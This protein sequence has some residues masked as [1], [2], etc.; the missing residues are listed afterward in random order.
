[1]ALNLPLTRTLLNMRFPSGTGIVSNS[2]FHFLRRLY[3]RCH[4]FKLFGLE[5]FF[6]FFFTVIGD[7][8]HKGRERRSESQQ[9]GESLEAPRR[10]RSIIQKDSLSVHFTL[11]DTSMIP[12]PYGAWFTLMIQI[13]KDPQNPNNWRLFMFLPF[14]Y[15]PC[16]QKPFPLCV[17]KNL[18]DSMDS[19][20]I[21]GTEGNITLF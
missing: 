3:I 14:C 1:M 6:L 11:H 18:Q 21:A 19:S 20:R 12:T 7:G 10:R 4:A 5:F 13:H 2:F 8:R 15:F 16:T 9:T 17:E